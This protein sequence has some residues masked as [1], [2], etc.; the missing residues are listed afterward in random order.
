MLLMELS[1]WLPIWDYSPVF[2]SSSFPSAEGLGEKER[3]KKKLL[4]ARAK[5]IFKSYKPITVCLAG[6]VCER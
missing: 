1:P 2:S 6:T 3:K 5:K 4:L